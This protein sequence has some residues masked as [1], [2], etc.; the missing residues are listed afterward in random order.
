MRNAVS[1]IC[2]VSTKV[3]SLVG[4]N[5]LHFTFYRST[6]GGASRASDSLP[7]FFSSFFLLSK[8]KINKNNNE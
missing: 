5:F 7:A 2:K 4:Y 3:M 8:T 1:G 6:L